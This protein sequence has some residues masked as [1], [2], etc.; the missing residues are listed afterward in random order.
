MFLK[1]II[2]NCMGLNTI[3]TGYHFNNN[4]VKLLY[5]AKWQTILYYSL[6]HMPQNIVWLWVRGTGVGGWHI[7]EDLLTLHIH[8]HFMLTNAIII[9]N[10]ITLQCHS[11]QTRLICTFDSQKNSIPIYINAQ[12]KTWSALQTNKKCSA[13]LQI[14]KTCICYQNKHWIHTP[15]DVEIASEMS[16]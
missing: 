10:W 6:L 3:I 7:Y 16:N 1:F 4:I 5:Y 8:I 15:L 9:I 14:Y 11:S 2:G 12:D 13:V